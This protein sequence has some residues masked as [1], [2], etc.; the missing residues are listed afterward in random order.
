M[1]K[2]PLSSRNVWLK[3]DVENVPFVLVAVGMN[4]SKF[5][6]GSDHAFI[7]ITALGSAHCAGLVQPTV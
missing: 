7:G 3:D 4:C 5:F 1:R 2:L 6:A